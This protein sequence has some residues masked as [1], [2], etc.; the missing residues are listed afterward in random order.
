MRWNA[1]HSI[2][3][4]QD[5]PP[6]RMA[7]NR[8]RDRAILQLIDADLAREGAVRLV[9]D[10]LRRDFDALAEV[11]AAEEEVEAWWGDDD[12]CCLF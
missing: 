8:P 5:N 7:D 4:L 3:L 10:V 2:I 11:L 6:L 9:E 12:F 1:T